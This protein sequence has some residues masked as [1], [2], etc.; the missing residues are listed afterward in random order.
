MKVQATLSVNGA[1][2]QQSRQ[3]PERSRLMSSSVFLLHFSIA[4][5]AHSTLVACGTVS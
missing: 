3:S 4:S 5:L 2:R 1:G